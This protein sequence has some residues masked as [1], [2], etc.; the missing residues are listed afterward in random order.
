MVLLHKIEKYLQTFC[1]CCCH[2]HGMMLLRWWHLHSPPDLLIDA[3]CMDYCLIGLHSSIHD[4]RMRFVPFL[5]AHIHVEEMSLP[6][7]AHWKQLLV[8]LDPSRS[9]R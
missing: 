8:A 9:P 1:S 2:L 7:S 5:N 3:K 6:D 4:A